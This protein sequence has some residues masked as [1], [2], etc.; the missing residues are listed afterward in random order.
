MNARPVVVGTDGSQESLL[1]VDWGAR[2]ARLRGTSLRIVSA[3]PMPP[4]MAALQ[5]RP[6]RDT[7]ASFLRTNRDQA[8]G[9]AIARAA[10]IAPDLRVDP[11][12]LHEAPAPAVTQSGTHAALLV[13]GAC[14]AG[15]FSAMMLGSVSR[16]AASHAACPV[17]IVRDQAGTVHRQIGVGVGDPDG[18]DGTLAFA[19]AEASL[20]RTGL[21]VLHAWQEPRTPAP[22]IAGVEDLETL[23]AP[24]RA[25]YPGVPVTGD[26]VHDHPAQALSGLCSRTQLVIIGRHTRRPGPQGPGAIQHAVLNHAHGPVAIVPLP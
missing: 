17:V 23:L 14:G 1:A 26:V 22:R 18:C 6:E 21:T 2:E 19:F 12:A 16:Y 8:L 24:W 20:R 3:A 11:I 9:A 7:V 4:R 25:K 15:A 10:A 5:L 13:L